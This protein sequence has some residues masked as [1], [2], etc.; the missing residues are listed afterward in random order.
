M[1]FLGL[2]GVAHD[3]VRA[4]GAFRRRLPENRDLAPVPL[5]LVAAVHHLEHSVRAGLHRQVQ[6]L[7]D[8]VPFAYGPQRPV[9]HVRRMAG[10]KPHTRRDFRDGLQ[11]VA[12]PFSLVPPRVHGLSQERHVPRAAS[13]QAL[14]LPNDA[15]HRAAGHPSPHRRQPHELRQLVGIMSTQYEVYI[16]GLLQALGFLGGADA[17]GEGDSFYAAFTAQAVEFA[18]M[19]LYAVHGV[20][21]DVARI[22]DD[23]IGILVALDLSV[24]RVLYHAP[25]PVGVV[26]VHLATEGP[27][28]GGL[29]AGGCVG[30]PT[31]RGLAG[32]RY[33]GGGHLAGCAIHT[34]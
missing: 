14:D 6:P 1:I 30:T 19:S 15:L 26:H 11:E 25:Y 7:D 22:E 24:P 8:G 32:E 23:E 21:A 33:R 13:N 28:A 31:L 10:G 34:L 29:A 27:D 3:D 12:V 17:A 2:A 18:Q 4:Q 20:F 5:R 16:V 9:L